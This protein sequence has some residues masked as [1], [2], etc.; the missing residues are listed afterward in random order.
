MDEIKIKEIVSLFLKVPA[1]SITSESSIE[2]KAFPGSISF[3]RMVASLRKIGVSINNEMKLKTFGELLKLNGLQNDLIANEI[4]KTNSSNVLS[5]GKEKSGND[6]ENI[7]IDI[8]SMSEIPDVADFHEDLF[9]KENYSEKEIAHCLLQNNPR[10]SFA[11][12]WA[13]K[14]AIVK[15]DITIKKNK[16]NSIEIS[17]NT[18]GKPVHPQFSLSCSHSGDYAI[19]LAIKRKTLTNNEELP[20]S[21]MFYKQN[22]KQCTMDFN[23]YVKK[24]YVWVLLG[25]NMLT[26][27]FLLLH[28]IFKLI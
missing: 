23:K 21:Q 19:G 10:N 9:F 11:G 26:I 18:E 4:I 7:G 2:A 5:N 15:A 12:L 22:D 16:F 28:D 25:L 17:H 27:A 3:A 13:I 20:S 8:Q 6:I 14:E 1:S 24:R